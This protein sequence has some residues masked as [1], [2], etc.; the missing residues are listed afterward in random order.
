[1]SAQIIR[2]SGAKIPQREGVTMKHVLISTGLAALLFTGT[3]WGHPAP[4]VACEPPLRPVNDQDDLLW[5]RFLAEIDSFRACTQRHMEYHQRAV[6]AHQSEARR[7][8]EQ[9]NQ[10]VR[11]SLNAPEDFPWPPEEAE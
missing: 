10:F 5:Q 11:S 1:M 7:S 6:E 2:K 3:S 4:D 8:V 9:W